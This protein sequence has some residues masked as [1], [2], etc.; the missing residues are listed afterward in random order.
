MT[1]QTFIGK[2]A[3]KSEISNYIFKKFTQ[4]YFKRDVNVL[5]KSSLQYTGQNTGNSTMHI[6]FPESRKSRCNYV[7]PG[8]DC[9]FRRWANNL[10]IYVSGTMIEFRW[11]ENGSESVKFDHP[12]WQVQF[13]YMGAFDNLGLI[14]IKSSK[15]VISDK[16]AMNKWIDETI[17]KPIIDVCDYLVIDKK[18]PKEMGDDNYVLDNVDYLLKQKFTNKPFVKIVAPI[19]KD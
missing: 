15:P 1:Y 5:N 19:S 7:E 10:C 8:Y 6:V 2:S 18:L 11:Y 9:N 14:T 12:A 4:W 13:D 16:Q 17:T 3:I